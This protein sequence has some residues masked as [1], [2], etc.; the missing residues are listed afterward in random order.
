MTDFSKAKEIK[1]LTATKINENMNNG[2]FLNLKLY[3]DGL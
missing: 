2:F 3:K 1:P